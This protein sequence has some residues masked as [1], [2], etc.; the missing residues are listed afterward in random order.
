MLDI[1]T[2]NKSSI[3]NRAELQ[4]Q[5]RWPDWGQASTWL[6]SPIS[7]RALDWQEREL[8]TPK[9]LLGSVLGQFSVVPQSL[10]GQTSLV[11]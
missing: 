7:P 11:N 2:L 5:I 9:H 8:F 4:L 3:N 10:P 6:G 1:Y